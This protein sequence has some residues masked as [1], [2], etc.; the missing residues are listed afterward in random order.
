MT[1]PRHFD[2]RTVLTT[3]H[4]AE[5]YIVDE[6]IV[7]GIQPKKKLTALVACDVECKA[8]DPNELKFQLI[9]LRGD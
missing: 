8:N 2:T 4:V 5:V 9:H 6:T 3:D 1:V 7:A